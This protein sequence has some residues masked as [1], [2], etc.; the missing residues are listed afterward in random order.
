MGLGTSPPACWSSP[1]WESKP[2]ILGNSVVSALTLPSACHHL[3]EAPDCWL[4]CVLSP[5]LLLASSRSNPSP[6][7]PRS[8]STSN[9]SPR[10]A[11]N[12]A[13]TASQCAS[14]VIQPTA[15]ARAHP[16]KRIKRAVCPFSHGCS[17][18]QKQCQLISVRHGFLLGAAPVS[19]AGR[20]VDGR[21]ASMT[22]QGR[23]DQHPRD[24][25]S[26]SDT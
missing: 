4:H 10:R 5:T 19:T 25:F 11:A 21:Q 22:G 23:G 14:G 9:G 16:V 18:S 13:V 12:P 7:S 15:A 6:P 17:S 20:D 8:C 2:A 1:R 26:P 3:V 24:A